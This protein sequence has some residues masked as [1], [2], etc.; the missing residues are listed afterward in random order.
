MGLA[1]YGEPTFWPQMRQ[2][3]RLQTDGALRARP[4]LLPPSPREDRLRVGGRQPARRH[5]V[6]AGARGAAR[7]RARGKDEPL[8]QRHHDIARSVQAMYEE[9]FFHLLD[10]PARRASARQPGAR[11]RLR[12]ELGRQRQGAARRRRSSGSTCSRRP[13]TPAARSAPRCTSGT[14]CE[15]GEHGTSARSP[16]TR[17]RPHVMEHAYLGPAARDEEIAALLD[18][19]AGEL[20]AQRLPGRAH[21]RRGRALPAHGRARSPTARWSAGSRGAWSGAR[22]RSATARS[23][24][25]PRRADMKDILNL[26]IKRREIVPPVRAVDPARST[27]P[28]GSRRT[29]TCRS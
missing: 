29:T 3:V 10:A 16:A 8:E 6:L 22:A 15:A 14:A 26:K 9:A 17:C 4:R 1:P 24:C 25:D 12:H 13:A 18:A 21:R 27:S 28:S 7:A 5:A 19:H 11:R 23:S 20:D 2:I